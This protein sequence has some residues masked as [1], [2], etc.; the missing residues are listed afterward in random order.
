M[1]KMIRPLLNMLKHFM[2]KMIRPLLNKAIQLSLV[3]V[4]YSKEKWNPLAYRPICPISALLLKI[5]LP[6]PYDQCF[7]HLFGQLKISNDKCNILISCT[8]S[9]PISCPNR[10]NYK[11]AT[12]K[13][14]TSNA[15][16]SSFFFDLTQVDPLVV[17]C[18]PGQFVWESES[19]FTK[20]CKLWILS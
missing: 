10:A 8:I 14:L 11:Q 13:F 15:K 4:D 3:H 12:K 16:N 5:H 18:I 7:E 6:I 20:S 19:W 9:C 2:S 17:N 1:S